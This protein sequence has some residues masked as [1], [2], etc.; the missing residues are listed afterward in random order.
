MKR[1]RSAT[2]RRAPTKWERWQIRYPWH[3]LK[4][5][6]TELHWLN[7][8]QL[9]HADGHVYVCLRRQ[10]PADRLTGGS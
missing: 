8:L 9:A 5:A 3:D 4:D 10:W 6:E 1:R 7:L 2:K